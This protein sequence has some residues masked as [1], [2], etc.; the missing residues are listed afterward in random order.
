MKHTTKAAVVPLPHTIKMVIF[1]VDGVILDLWA[2]FAEN[3]IRAAKWMG[4]PI[5]PIRANLRPRGNIHDGVRT[6]WPNLTDQEAETFIAYF[7]EVERQHPYPLIAGASETI[8][9]TRRH[10]MKVALC[11]T[12][13]RIVLDHRLK[14]ARID[15]SWFSG[16]NTWECYRKPDLR[17]LISLCDDAGVESSAAIYV[18]DEYTDI[19]T[20]KRAGVAFLGAL[21]G[22]VP[23]ESF[24]SSGVPKAHIISSIAD[25]PNLLKHR[26]GKTVD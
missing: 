21:S 12:N 1:D 23:K 19:E 5:E 3:N 9:W 17:A 22:R 18:G 16:M 14:T 4:L 11:T 20:A 10:G 26:V 24:L 6:I 15:P 13:E 7:R 2:E 8:E 25:L